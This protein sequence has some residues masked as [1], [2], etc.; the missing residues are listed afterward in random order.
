MDRNTALIAIV[1]IMVLALVG[2]YVY[3][4]QHKDTIELSVGKNGVKI[5]GPSN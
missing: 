3:N 4:Q 2:A 1:G 5:E